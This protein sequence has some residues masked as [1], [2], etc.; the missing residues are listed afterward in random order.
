MSKPLGHSGVSGE[1]GQPALRPV[2]VENKPA[3]KPVS[4]ANT[5][6]RAQG[7]KQPSTSQSA[8]EW[9]VKQGLCCRMTVK[10][11]DIDI[12]NLLKSIFQQSLYTVNC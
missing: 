10:Y 11:S 3:R 6:R 8:L 5:G 7:W 12:K 1:D 9:K 2:V 4:R